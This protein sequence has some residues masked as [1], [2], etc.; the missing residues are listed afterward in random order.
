MSNNLIIGKDINGTVSDTISPSSEMYRAALPAGVAIDVTVPQG[1]DRVF[2][3]Y[4]SSGDVWVD[5]QNDATIPASTFELTTS[6]LRPASRFVTP[7]NTVSCIC[8]VINSIQISF[9]NGRGY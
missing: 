1:V 8:D 2:F 6:E 7:G 5:L 3:S 4:G 9:Y